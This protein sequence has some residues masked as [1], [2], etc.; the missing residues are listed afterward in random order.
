MTPQY[1]ISEL[2][3]SETKYPQNLELLKKVILVAYLGRLQING[4]SPDNNITLGDYLF[5]E[6]RM[7]F[8]YTRL[9]DEKKMCYLNG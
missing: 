4:Q 8:D 7:I 1:V 6:E 2:L 3:K 9:S 5:D